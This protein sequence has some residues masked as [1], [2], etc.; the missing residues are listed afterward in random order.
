MQITKQQ[1]GDLTEIKIAGRL[2]AYWADHLNKELQAT[3]REGNHHLVLDLSAV[4]YISSAGIRVL[5]TFYNQ[6]NQIRGS[7]ALSK[8]SAPARSILEMA[9]LSELLL[10]KSATSVPSPAIVE[11]R[12][13]ESDRATYEIFP[14]QPKA[15]MNCRIIGKPE[16]LHDS[17]IPAEPE[18][19]RATKKSIAIGLGAFGENWEQSKSRCGEFLAAA[20]AAAYLP[21]DGTNIPDYLI[22]SGTYFPE[23]LVM[24]GAICTGDFSYL[25]RFESKK[26]HGAVALVE[27]LETAMSTCDTARMAAVLIGEAAGLVGA[28]LLKSPAADSI[29]PRIFEYP[30][31]LNWLSFTA[32]RAHSRSLAL[33]VG[34]TDN[35]QTNVSVLRPLDAAGKFSGH[36]HAAAFPYRPLRKGEL[37]LGSTISTLFEQGTVEGVLHLLR[38]DRTIGGAGESEFIRGACWVGPIH[39]VSGV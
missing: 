13:M 3:I 27:V 12:K 19:I 36:F 20:G 1:S 30:E 17:Q 9:G 23:I 34:I 7:L 2:D 31:T 21:T 6:L 35:A 15:S 4:E 33:V 14:L 5:L 18:K 16:G 25:L 8:V 11:I 10:Q 39:E 28:S 24:Y 37:E 29:I 32:E 26:E 22:S 38:D